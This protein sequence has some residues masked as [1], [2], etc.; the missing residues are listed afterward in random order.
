MGDC[1]CANSGV[2][3]QGATE[4]LSQGEVDI[5]AAVAEQVRLRALRR[6]E[7]ARPAGPAQVER[8]R[9]R[10]ELRPPSRSPVDAQVVSPC[11]WQFRADGSLEPARE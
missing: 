2:G 4:S 10:D 11:T 7:L 5:L 1:K 3:K 8:L 6:T 9:R